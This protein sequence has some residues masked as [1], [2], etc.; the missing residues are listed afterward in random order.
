MTSLIDV[1]KDAPVVDVTRIPR[2][3]DE[4]YATLTDPHQRAMLRVMRRHV[5][6]ESSGYWWEV[7]KPELAVTESLFYR[8]P[9]EGGVGVEYDGLDRVSEFYKLL[10]SS[11]PLVPFERTQYAV[12][13]HSVLGEAHLAGFN[14]GAELAEQ[15]TPGLDDEGHYLTTSRWLYVFEFADDARV[16][17]ERIYDGGEHVIYEVAPENVLTWEDC[18]RL[19]KPYLDNPPAE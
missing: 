16:T 5:L 2:E 1:R 15:G 19:I 7:L 4:L 8:V 9:M 18:E 11:G 3:M 17:G 13:D 6:L 12:T 10:R 14:T